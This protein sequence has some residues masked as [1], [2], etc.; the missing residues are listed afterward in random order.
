MQLPY[1]LP[2]NIICLTEESVETLYAIGL[3]DIVSGVSIFVKRPK[4]AMSKPKVSAFTSSKIDE[5]VG[6]KP[7]L[8]I[9]FSDIQKDI[10]RELIERGMNVYI[11]NQRS[12]Q[13]ILSYIFTLCSMVGKP[14]EGEELV[15]KM[16]AKIQSISELSAKFKIQ[17]KVYFEEWDEPMI[18]GIKWVSECIEF[19]GGVD[20]FKDRSRGVL[21][22]ERFLSSEEV[23]KHN[24]DIILACWCGK[25]VKKESFFKRDGWAKI[26]AVKNNQI[27]ELEPE[28]FL[29]PGPAP[30]LD[31]LDILYDIL[32]QWVLNQSE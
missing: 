18:S 13:E 14:A 2:R 23:I 28:I 30:F 16:K 4:E 25:K 1:S 24:P 29:Q 6:M 8:V 10:A 20:I 3:Q 27:Y 19:C 12:T 7:D 17:P 22:R 11:T 26:K 15:E 5:I 32:N 21:A 31:G 9:G